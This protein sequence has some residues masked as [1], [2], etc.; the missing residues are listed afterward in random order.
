MKTVPIITCEQAAEKV[1][2]GNTMIVGGFGMTGAP[3][4]LLHALAERDVKDLTFVGNNIGEPGL[5][6]GRLLRNKQIKS[7]VGSYFTSNKEA[8]T[9]AQ[10]GDID[11]T[12]LPQGT[13]AEAIRAGGAGIGGFF[14]PTAA[15]TALAE[16][17]ETREINGTRMIFI[18]PIRGDV[19]LVRAWRADTA[20]N[21]QYRMT[22]R[23]FNV[24]AATAA[25]TV[26]VEVEE[27]ED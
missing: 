16:G 21:L 14:T 24:A 9:A 17:C 22:E 3:V 7:A 6:G 20:G 23:N 8:V 19:A 18:E 25:D 27:S 13:L 4:H 1:Q 2:S 26:L 10:S 12:L 5:G 11:V 15:D